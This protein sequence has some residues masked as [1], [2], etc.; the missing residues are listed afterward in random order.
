VTSLIL[1][2]KKKVKAQQKNYK[3]ALKLWNY[4]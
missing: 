4:R 1:S 3:V 2:L